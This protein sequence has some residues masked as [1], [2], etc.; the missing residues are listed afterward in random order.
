MLVYPRNVSVKSLKNF[1]KC[2]CL[3]SQRWSIMPGQGNSKTL[4]SAFTISLYKKK[5]VIN[6][7]GALS[8]RDKK[9][10]L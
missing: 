8:K 4:V 6:Q 7:K 1:A 9:S 10:Y 2:L 3:S 5:I